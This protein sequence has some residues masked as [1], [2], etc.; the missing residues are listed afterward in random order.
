MSRK[1]ILLPYFPESQKDLKRMKAH[2]EDV[3]S[4]KFQL[5]DDIVRLK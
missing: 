4:G 3:F 2:L 1:N 5:E